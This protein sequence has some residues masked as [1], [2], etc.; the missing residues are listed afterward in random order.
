MNKDSYIG[1]LLQD[2]RKKNQVLDMIMY[3]NQ[4][5]KD[6]LTDPNLDPDEFDKI[7]EEKAKLIE[8]LEQ[9]DDGFEKIYDY[10]REELKENKEAHKE[11]ILEMQNLI[12]QLTEKSASIQAQE[13][14]NK[15]LMKNKFTE[16][17]Q[18]VREIRSSQKVVNQYYQ[19]MMKANY[20]DPQF[21]DNKK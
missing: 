5:Q 10:V 16:V 3:A 8:R 2:L 4:R 13:Q 6:A 18:H 12:R 19:N 14:R 7:V 15:E 20:I 11:E 17:K 1:I 9:L 21:M